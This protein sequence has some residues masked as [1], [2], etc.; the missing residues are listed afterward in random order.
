MSHSGRLLILG[1]ACLVLAGCTPQRDKADAKRPGARGTSI[2][3]TPVPPKPGNLSDPCAARVHDLSGLLL[4][5]YAVNKSLP[6]NLSDMASLADIDVEFHDE[7]PASGQ[8][9]AYVPQ[10][11][12]PAGSTQFLILYDSV[13]AHN[14]L[15]WGVFIT[16]PKDGQPPATRAILMSE[17]VFR[18]HAPQ[19]PAR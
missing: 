6:E 2:T 15:R 9:Y 8:P 10:A 19:Q 12:P 1:L 18:R 5:Y 7:C 4:L 16:P 17:E 3:G 11:V 14:G 13:P